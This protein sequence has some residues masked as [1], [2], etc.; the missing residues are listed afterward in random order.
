MVKLELKAAVIN[1]GS[2]FTLNHQWIPDLVATFIYDRRLKEEV[3]IPSGIKSGYRQ[4]DISQS[5][6]YENP[7]DAR[8][9]AAELVE[10]FERA[11]AQ[12]IPVSEAVKDLL[13]PA[14]AMLRKAGMESEALVLEQKFQTLMEQSKTTDEPLPASFIH[15]CEESIAQARRLRQQANKLY[16]DARFIEA[17]PLIRRA[18]TIAERSFGKDHPDVARDLNN[19][20]TLL[21]AT[22]RLAE[23]EPL[24]RR[25][26]AIDE[27]NFGKDHPDVAIDIS[28]LATLLQA[29]NRLAEADMLLRRASVIMETSF[30]KEHPNF[31]TVLEN[32]GSVLQALCLDVEAKKR[33]SHPGKDACAEADLNP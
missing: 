17:E 10:R 26:L 27:R 20:A 4:T 11:L 14:L 19:L 30:G 23:A 15:N 5:E 1:K 29:T 6:H 22:N 25:A 18:L 12:E 2:N 7:V 13:Y 21:Q 8:Q 28:N 31:V 24:M 32:H 9:F 3:A 33:R 16:K